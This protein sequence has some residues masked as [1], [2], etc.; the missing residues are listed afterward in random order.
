MTDL[1]VIIVSYK[2]WG[3][4]TKCLKALNAFTG[5]KFSTE[6]IVVDNNSGDDMI[7]KIAVQFPRFTF[8]HNEVNGGFASGCN[9]GARSA[10]GRFLLFLNPDTVASE[11]EVGKLIDIAIKNPDITILTCRQVNEKGTECNV[12][13]PFPGFNNLT[14]FQRAV[15]KLLSPEVKMKNKSPEIPLEA[16]YSDIEFPDWVSGSV[17]LMRKDSFL[18]L[19]GFDDDYWMYFEDVD[20]CRRVSD[21]G[22]VIAYCRDT[23]IEHNHGGSSRTDLKTTSLTKT[24]VFISRHVYIS[25]HKKGTGKFLI[26]TFLVL[27]NLITGGLTALM[28][29]V[30][31]FIP[32]AFARTLIYF[33]LI[34]YYVNSTFRSSWI[35]P[36]SVNYH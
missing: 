33:R 26:Q 32:K 30:L 3:P 17:I 2:G 29:L 12:T 5:E 35:S 8:V 18:S 20:I 24:E 6:V 16:F 1:S 27:N 36:R 4:L 11:S 34:R 22:G 10:G 13:G 7:N 28:G 9:L 23:T 15:S 14:G 21:S 31:F 19:H 25:K